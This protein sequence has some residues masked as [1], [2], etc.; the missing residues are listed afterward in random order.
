MLM[1][2]PWEIDTEIYKNE[3]EL[4]EGLR[5]KEKMACTCMLKR[6]ARRLYTLARRL[7][8]NNEEAEEILQESF[9]QACNHI[10]SF[11]G[12]S[13]LHTWLY[14]I[15]VNAALMNRRRK[16][17]ET[18]PLTEEVDEEQ[19][20]SAMTLVDEE[21]TPDNTI[22]QIEIRTAIQEALAQLPETLRK[23]FILR[24]VEGF[25]TKAAAI[26]LGIEE[27][28]LKVRVYRARQELQK[29]LTAYQ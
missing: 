26:Q 21:N 20:G 25:S 2:M 18:Q 27:S 29:L 16:I 17:L 11:E 12:K 14:R 7:V 22:L 9:I 4:L 15:V 19:I 3:E 1:E 24:H 6:F 5:R 13:A 10:S 8:N 28:A 23:A